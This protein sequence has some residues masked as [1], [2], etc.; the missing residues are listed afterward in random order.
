MTADMAYFA[1]LRVAYPSF[2]AVDALA[3]YLRANPDEACR[4]AYTRG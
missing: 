4:L 3:L 2:P 1:G